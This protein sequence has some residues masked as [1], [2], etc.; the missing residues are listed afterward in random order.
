MAESDVNASYKIWAVDNVVY[1]PVE[2]PILI[3]W[4]KEERVTAGTWIHVEH[5]DVWRRA[6]QLPELQEL[7]RHTPVDIAG[8]PAAVAPANA[9]VA[10]LKPGALR[11]IRILSNLSDLQLERFKQYLTLQSVRQWSIIVKQGDPGDA[12]YLVI[13]GEVRVRLM[14]AGKERIITTLPVGDFFGEFCLFDHGPRSADV[15]ANKDSQLLKLSAGQF[16]K[17]LAEAPDLAVPFFLAL[18]QT[19]AARIRAD[20]KRFRDFFQFAQAAR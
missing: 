9:S 1:G 11:R 15:V 10:E 16:H 3:A 6:A 12:M 14:I 2:L 17:L 19:L 5:N 4:I 18:C 7:F 13:E 8:P 20:N